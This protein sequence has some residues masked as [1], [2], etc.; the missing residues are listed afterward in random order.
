MRG[1]AAAFGLDPNDDRYDLTGL[2][3]LMDVPMPPSGCSAVY[4]PPST[5]AS[6]R[7]YLSRNYDFSI[8]SLA[9]M[10]GL[11]LP[12]PVRATPAAV[13][14]APRPAVATTAA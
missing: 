2:T 10:M 13:H 8:G 3:Y 11:P 7:G 5:T 14:R 1:V 6:G 12:P 4:H 9:D